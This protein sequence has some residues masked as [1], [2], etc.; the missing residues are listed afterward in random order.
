[1]LGH[2][3]PAQAWAVMDFSLIEKKVLITAGVTVTFRSL[4]LAN[5]RWA[6]STRSSMLYNKAEQR[7]CRRQQGR[8]SPPQ[9]GHHQ[10]FFVAE[11]P[12]ISCRMLTLH[13]CVCTVAYRTSLVNIVT[14]AAL[15]P[16]CVTCRKLGGFGLDFFMVRRRGRRA[17]TQCQL[18]LRPCCQQQVARRH[19]V[20]A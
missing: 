3:L 11:W 18:S 20:S 19:V 14:C 4:I 15:Y 9:G 17:H 1:M 5:V 13:V 16:Y 10:A 6:P 2:T 12:E 7:L 8:H